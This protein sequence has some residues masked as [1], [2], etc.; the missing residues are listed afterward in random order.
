MTKQ[1]L[2]E[3]AYLRRWLFEVQT[4]ARL[5]NTQRLVLV[6]GGDLGG[7]IRRWRIKHKV[8]DCVF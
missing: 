8:F 4:A 3:R 1:E 7:L 6:S 2:A 5:G